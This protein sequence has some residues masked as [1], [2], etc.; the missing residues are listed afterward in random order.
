[1]AAGHVR[2]GIKVPQGDLLFP[3]KQVEKHSPASQYNNKSWSCFDAVMNSNLFR[4]NEMCR[5]PDW[6]CRGGLFIRRRGL[7]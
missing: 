1:M 4:R 5:V 3:H 7:S 6:F 2:G